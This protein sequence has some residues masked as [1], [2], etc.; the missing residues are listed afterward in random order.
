MEST[1]AIQTNF[2][3]YD[4]VIKFIVV[5]LISD[6]WSAGRGLPVVPLSV[7]SHCRIQLEFQRA[8]DVLCFRRRTSLGQLLLEQS[9][10]I[11]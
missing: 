1:A 11:L 2:I 4:L 10:F 9:H 6:G 3:L 5:R 7:S 8:E